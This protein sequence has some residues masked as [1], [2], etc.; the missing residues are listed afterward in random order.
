MAKAKARFSAST[1]VTD[2]ASTVTSVQREV[3]GEIIGFLFAYAK[4]RYLEAARLVSEDDPLATRIKS[5]AGFDPRV[6]KDAHDQIAAYYSLTRMDLS[7]PAGSP[8][9]T[10]E[11][12]AVTRTWRKYFHAEARELAQDDRVAR[13]I[14]TAVALQHTE[15]GMRSEEVLMDRLR[16]RYPLPELPTDQELRAQHAR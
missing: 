6:L 13:A 2:S 9:Q 4:E 1:R 14:L 15:A 8:P 10:G 16:A 3:F 11:R 12:E 5:M 7:Q